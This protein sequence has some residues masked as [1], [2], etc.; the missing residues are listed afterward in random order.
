MSAEQD[1]AKPAGGKSSSSAQFLRTKRFSYES[2]E[3]LKQLERGFVLDGV[4]LSRLA[5][6]ETDRTHPS[7]NVGIPQYRARQ[8]KHCKSYFS[9][10][11]A[12]PKITSSPHKVSSYDAYCDENR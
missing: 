12:L 3:R 5:N 11:K 2:P 7:L 10:N 9:S 1:K 8:D 4:A 6:E